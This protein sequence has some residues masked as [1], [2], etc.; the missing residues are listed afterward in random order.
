MDGED[1]DFWTEEF[2]SLRGQIIDLEIELTNARTDK[3][4]LLVELEEARR[5]LVNSELLRKQQLLVPLPSPS[6]D[7][8]RERYE[9][10]QLVRS[11][12]ERIEK[13]LSDLTS[14]RLDRS[15]TEMNVVRQIHR[16]MDRIDDLQFQL[17]EAQESAA[18]QRLAPSAEMDSETGLETDALRQVREAAEERVQRAEDAARTAKDALR[19]V[20]SLGANREPA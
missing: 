5:A 3:D 20:M 16:L 7:H 17:A 6:A 8:D 18:A 4:S 1:E 11:K 13:L 10:Q 9:V 19:T 12:D 14:E 2:R 15:A